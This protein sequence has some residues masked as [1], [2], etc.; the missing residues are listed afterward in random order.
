ML[1]RENL[2]MHNAMTS[3]AARGERRGRKQFSSAESAIRCRRAIKR[4][5]RAVDYADLCQLLSAR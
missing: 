3:A 5:S 1:R 2:T 4:D